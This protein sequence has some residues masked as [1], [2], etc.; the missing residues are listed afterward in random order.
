MA[1]DDA[2]KSVH[3]T[4]T[5]TTADTIKLTQWWDAIEVENRDAAQNLYVR[6]DGTTAVAL[7]EGTEIVTP[8]TSKVFV[9]GIQRSG[10]IPGNTTTPPHQLSVVG[11]G[12]AY[13][14]I[15]IPGLL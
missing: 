13:S 4:L 10:G 12:N 15:G 9:A 11:S 2:V 6:F 8:G 3:L 7:A 1:T 5:T 14:V